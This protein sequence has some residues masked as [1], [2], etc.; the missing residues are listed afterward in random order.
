MSQSAHS[1][2][3]IRW[4]TRHGTPQTALA[5]M[6]LATL[7]ATGCAKDV[8]ILSGFGDSYNPEGKFRTEGRHEGLDVW[9]NP[10]DPVL[11]SADGRVVQ[12][13]E[14]SSGPDRVSCGKFIILTHPIGGGPVQTI[15]CHLATQKVIIGQAIKRGDVIGTIGT[16]GWRHQPTQRTGYEHVH[17]EFR[18]S[19][20]ST[21]RRAGLRVDPSPYTAGCFDRKR[22]YPTDG[23]ALTYPVEC[24]SR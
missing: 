15:Y 24:V 11:A 21:E 16:T 9:G 20:T 3:G 8:R 7:L 14:E 6:V 4:R 1:D 23:L 10:G 12:V 19:T 22:Q 13:M 17:W 5:M 18:V 2:R